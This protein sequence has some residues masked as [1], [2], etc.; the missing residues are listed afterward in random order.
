MPIRQ[1]GMA[2]CLFA[3]LGSGCVSVNAY[4]EDGHDKTDYRELKPRDPPTPVQ[5]VCEYT[6]NGEPE[7]DVDSTICREVARVLQQTQVLLPAETDAAATLKVTVDDRS[8]LARD[9]SEGIMTGATQGKVGLTARDDFRFALSLLNADGAPPQSGLYDHAMITVAGDAPV[10]GYGR[11]RSAG[12][13]F[14]V[15]V[16]QSVL[17]FLHD[18]QATAGMDGPVM[19][20]PDTPTPP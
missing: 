10:P 13:A 1:L 20:V 19:F 15:I 14:A 16:Q 11:P 2:G 5:M 8:D 17:E 6:R 3:L 18:I 12:D 7:P 4:V 9:R